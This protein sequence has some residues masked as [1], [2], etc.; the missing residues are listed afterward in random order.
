MLSRF[1][2][3]KYIYLNKVL[4]NSSALKY[5]FNSLQ[6]SHP[7]AEICPVLKSNA[8]GH[9][10]KQ[11]APIFDKLGAP[12]LIVD[13]LYEAYELYKL[14]IKTPILIIGYTSPENFKV[15]RL[16][17]HYVVFDLHLAEVLNKYQPHCKVH[18]FIDT[19]MNR[20]GVEVERLRKFVRDIKKLKN[21]RIDGLCSHFADAD[22]PSTTESVEAQIGLYKGALQILKDEGVNP[23]WRHISASSGSIKVND[24]TFNMIRAGIAL[25]GISPLIKKDKYYR[26]V[27]LKPALKFISTIVQ[28]KEVT[29]GNGVGYNYT[30]KVKKN[31]KIAI[32]PAGYYEGVDRRLSNTGLVKVNSKYCPIVGRV[33]MNM[34]TIDVSRVGE[35]KV[36]DK[37]VIYSDLARDKNSIYNS[38]KLVGTIPYELITKLSESVRRELV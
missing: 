2:R 27:K 20:E 23:K 19:G 38:A 13:S 36:G 17:F 12:F 26:R 16:P 9:G 35:I 32:L 10:L 37:V 29:K 15:K 28:I 18:I 31:M 22:N 5:N 24:K 8:Y 7:E 6:K 21:I 3:R 4:I 14:R 11:V 25:Y 33:S 30:F 34:A 1:L